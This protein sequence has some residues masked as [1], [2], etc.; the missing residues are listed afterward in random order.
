MPQL[1]RCGTVFS[2]LKR[3]S[4]FLPQNRPGLEVLWNFQSQALHSLHVEGGIFHVQ[5]A[6]RRFCGGCSALKNIGAELSDLQ[7]ELVIIHPISPDTVT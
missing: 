6:D 5:H 7:P 1:S 2:E 4:L 3:H